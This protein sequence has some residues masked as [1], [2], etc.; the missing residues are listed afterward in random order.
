MLLFN[1]Q[2]CMSNV[3]EQCG[4]QGKG[5]TLAS[6]SLL[7]VHILPTVAMQWNNH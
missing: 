4:L 5:T 1:A 7:A 2:H 6:N 3:N